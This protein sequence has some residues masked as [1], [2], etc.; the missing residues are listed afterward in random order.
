MAKN[1]IETV[2]AL[3][4]DL[5]MLKDKVS[6]YEE[7]FMANVKDRAFKAKENFEHK[8][9]ENPMASVGISFGAGVVTG[10]LAYALMKRGR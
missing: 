7:G 4:H 6:A 2:D 9:E 8:V 3:K 1:K 10:M 5:Q